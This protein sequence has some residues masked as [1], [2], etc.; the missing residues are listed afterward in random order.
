M[1]C[2][3]Q[4]C[5]SLLF[6]THPERCSTLIIH[7]SDLHSNFRQFPSAMAHCVSVLLVL[8]LPGV[9]VFVVVC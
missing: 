1:Q 7:P 2:E 4:N 9:V 8:V 5:C 6:E 3:S